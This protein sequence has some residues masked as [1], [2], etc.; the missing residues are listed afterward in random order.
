VTRRGSVQAWR[1]RVVLL[2]MKWRREI[3]RTLLACMAVG[4]ACTVSNGI[5]DTSRLNQG[6]VGPIS[7]ARAESGTRLKA[8]WLVG[9]DGS[10]QF[11]N[12][13]DTE[14]D[15]ECTFQSA[16]DGSSR[17]QPYSAGVETGGYSD[18][19]CTQRLFRMPRL[20][21]CT[22][23]APPRFGTVHSYDSCRAGR[24]TLFALSDRIQPGNVY[25]DTSGACRQRA[26]ADE[27]FI[28]FAAAEE[29]PPTRF[30]GAEIATDE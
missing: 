28:Y 22:A 20:D 5:D 10:R 16:S 24:F 23:A 18:A 29:L 25:D 17:C 2:G 8:R 4:V 3:V 12:W 11:V 6:E 13:R 30:V 19:A 15:A 27:D 9:S 26:G 21:D 1:V 14:L 7:E